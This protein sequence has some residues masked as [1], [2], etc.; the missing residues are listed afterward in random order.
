MKGN[1]MSNVAEVKEQINSLRTVL[2]NAYEALGCLDGTVVSIVQTSEAQVASAQREV[3]IAQTAVQSAVR[4]GT[5]PTR[6]VRIM[7]TLEGQYALRSFLEISPLLGMGR[8]E[9]VEVLDENEI[10]FVLKTR[11][12]DG[13][14]LIG[15]A[16]RN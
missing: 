5:Q 9:I 2:K 16:S 14:E 13:A 15:L 3:Q 12:R 8:D 1:I 6:L 10:R 11:R 4:E 7:A